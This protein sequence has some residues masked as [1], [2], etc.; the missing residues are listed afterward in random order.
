MLHVFFQKEVLRLSHL[1]R[2]RTEYCIPVIM[3]SMIQ[4]QVVEQLAIL[5]EIKSTQC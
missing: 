1:L 2:D 3:G 5:A 4:L